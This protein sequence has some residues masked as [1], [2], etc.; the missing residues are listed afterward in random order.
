MRTLKR[1]A[2]NALRIPIVTVLALSFIPLTADAAADERR[3]EISRTTQAY[4]SQF[5]PLWF[6]S[7]QSRFGQANLMVGP[8]R[9][10][11]IY[12]YVVAINNDTMYA[13]S[14][15]D[16][17]AEPVILTIPTTSTNYSVLTLDPYG[18]IFH[19][20]IKPPA[21]GMFA[22]YG[23][24]FK[25]TLPPELHPVPLP[26]D[27]MTII[28]RADRFTN[29]VDMTSEA[30]A[31]RQ[32][33]HTEPLCSYLGQTCPTGVPLGGGAAI[34]PEILFAVPF[35]TAADTLIAIDPIAFLRQLQR[36][37]NSPRTPPMSPQVQELSARFN[38]L[39]AR[40]AE[41]RSEFAGGA[42]AAHDAIVN[43]YLNHLGKTNWITYD[44]I[45]QW[46][47]HVVQRSSITEFLQ[48]GNDRETAAYYHAFKDQTGAPLDGT[49]SKGYVLTFSPKEIPATTRFWSL[50]AY[51]PE[52]IELVPNSADKYLVA[53]YTPGLQ[54]NADG[55]ISIYMARQRPA[56]VPAANWLPI[57]VGPFN[58]MLRD[59]GPAGD[60]A[61]KTYVPPGIV[62]AQ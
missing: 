54:T 59:Y 2:R 8:D 43:D 61:K 33:L 35:K 47:P 5:Y 14:F 60:V 6:T 26:F 32:L 48:Y 24:S 46:G 19:S 31:F 58:V 45:G 39:F 30:D 11:P 13:S 57:P 23:P 29:G 52:A 44:N 25:G 62:K 28:F 51:T 18:D 36:A 40:V 37:V 27:Y 1:F 34:V 15:L 17:S 53:S 22:L 9:I 20:A 50:T 10:S 16:L 4:V 38:A 3:G 7:N 41:N 21:P 55:S 12:H 42:R 56:S 49:D